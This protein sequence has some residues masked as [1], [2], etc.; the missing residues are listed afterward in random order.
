MTDID[1]HAPPGLLARF[2][3]DPNAIDGATAASLEAHLVRCAE[4][5]RAL[6]A[7]VDPSLITASWDAIAARIDVPREH[8][9]L[10]L[11]AWVGIDS[12]LA[13]ILAATPAL[14]AA[15]LA[16][17]VVVAAAAAVASRTSDGP[18]LLVAPLV[19]LA[20]VAAAF[21]SS[22]DPAGEA[23]IASPLHGVGLVVRRA[24]A[25]LGVTFVTLAVASLTLPDLGPRAASWVLPGLA[26]AVGSLA[27]G[28][29]VRI[30][31]A[32]SILAASWIVVVWTV[33]FAGDRGPV[34]DTATFAVAGQLASLAVAVAAAALVVVRRSRY[35]TLEAFR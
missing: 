22:S 32:V 21:A 25:V 35:A 28:T 2:A 19:P 31:V 15:G 27:L 17:I 14:Q 23:G 30:E 8:L 3:A 20:A 11:L 5:R 12:A 18:F 33:W 1:W 9:V 10:R 26:L 16:A 29:W 4:C 6:G 13:R 24:V 7:A 34:V